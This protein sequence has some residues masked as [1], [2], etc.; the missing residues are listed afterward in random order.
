MA[1]L[2]RR[3]PRLPHPPV[4]R[5]AGLGALLLALVL[6]GAS[7]A[8]ADGGSA[9]EVAEPGDPRL[10]R[11]E[12]LA[13]QLGAED[14]DARRAAYRALTT[15]DEEM[16]PAIR[17]RIAR[18]RRGRPERRWAVDILNRFRRRANGDEGERDDPA[19]GALEELGEE[20]GRRERAMVLQMA[21]PLMLWR[22]LDRIGTLEAQQAVFPL[23]G[24]D[25]GL[26]MPEARNWVRRREHALM[27][28]AILG[29]AG[30]G[31][32]VRRW[33]RWAMRHLGAD[34][35]GRAVQA[36]DEE[37]LPDVL[38]A[39]AELRM[40]S[41]MR[42]IVSYVDSERRRIRR[43]AREAL[44]RYGGNAI[45]ILRTAYHNEVGE[46]APDAWSWRR[47]SEELYAHVDA[48]RLAPVRAALEEG[49]AAQR[50]GDLATMR[51]RFDDVLARA[52]ELEEPAPVAEGYA[53]LA[54]RRLA[55]GNLREARW[56]YQRA[57]R[58]APEGP[59]ADAWRAQL[60]FVAAEAARR[61]GVLDVDA[62]E[63]VLAHDPDHAG[64]AA[65]LAAAPGARAA[66]PRPRGA[67]RTPWALAAAALLGLLGLAL[68]W[69]GE[70]ADADGEPE[71]EP[72]CETTL[73]APG[74][75]E[76]DA[77]LADST[78]PG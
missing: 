77:T 36:L 16:L 23:I 12:S 34:D 1:K 53:A 71:R 4:G 72:T 11:I 40:M 48:R 49:L 35:P 57:L 76:A 43:A 39:Y 37:L 28:A 13:R 67:D 32:Y 22:A 9:P 10:A 47:L 2:H 61:D 59:D 26:W 62:Y 68:L 18:L 5:A 21:E 41:A 33:G 74:F 55:E 50:R 75:D 44:A 3:I 56:A 8:R 14:A 31:R 15:L 58:L 6:G 52:P 30:E 20:H 19:V 65:A 27:A 24:L 46:H 17:A 66:R 60:T 78:L 70:E 63:R 54:E 51:A 45:W 69:R 38:R 7:P 64:A 29:R 25:R 42:V 73:E